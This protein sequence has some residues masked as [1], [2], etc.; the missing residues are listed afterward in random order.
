[1]TS[2]PDSVPVR[3]PLA[4]EAVLLGGQNRSGTTLL[5]VVLDAHPQLVVGPELDF[6]E[7][8]DLGPHIL[9]ACDLLARK[10]PRVLGPGTDTADPFWYDGAHFVKQCQR[11][12]IGLTEL[13]AAVAAVSSELGTDLARLADRCILIDRLGSLR[14]AQL[15]VARWGL[16]LQRRIRDVDVYARIWPRARFIHIVRDGR[17]LAASHLHSVPAWGFKSI[18]EAAREWLHVISRPHL[19]AP[20]GRYLEVRYEDLVTEPRR[21]TAAMTEFLDIPFDEAL[22]RH[23]D[24]PHALL[25]NPWAHPAAEAVARPITADRVGRHKTDLTAAQIAEFEEIAGTEL[26]RLGY[27]S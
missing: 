27:L 13:A 8:P 22:V 25:D 4:S 18:P 15:G 19:V 11:F 16:K 26:R 23:A 14:Q 3:P 6:T 10:D 12:G 5:S 20:P 7:P 1:M 24:Y 2:G 21:T 17:D 9:A